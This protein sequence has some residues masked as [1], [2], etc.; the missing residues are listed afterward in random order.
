MGKLIENPYHAVAISRE[1]AHSSSFFV[2]STIYCFENAE[3]IHEYALKFLIAKD[4]PYLNE[5]NE[6]VR[7]ASESGLIDKWRIDCHMRGKSK[8]NEKK[9]SRI[10][11]EN[12]YS[13]YLIWFP[14][15]LFQIMCVLLERFVHKKRYN[16]PE[17]RF[18]KLFEM[19]ID[20]DRHYLVENRCFHSN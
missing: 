8:R 7:R 15:M 4:F 16:H 2:D 18:W 14:L 20:S 9:F 6:F 3:V 10:K 13:V 5:L 1:H 19:F 17:S 12:F 11:M